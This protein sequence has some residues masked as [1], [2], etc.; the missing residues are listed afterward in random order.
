MKNNECLYHYVNLLTLIKNCKY[1]NV[2]QKLSPQRDQLWKEYKFM[3]CLI[4]VF[5]WYSWQLQ[6][7]NCLL[8]LLNFKKQ[9]Y[10]LLGYFRKWIYGSF[11]AQFSLRTYRVN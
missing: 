11:M 3:N 10:C 5:S 2:M 6:H 4:C 9:Q 1:V 7:L 8:K